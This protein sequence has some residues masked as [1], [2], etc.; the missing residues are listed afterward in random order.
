M[1]SGTLRKALTVTDPEG[2]RASA[3]SSRLLQES[4]VVAMD[5]LP[6]ASPKCFVNEQLVVGNTMY[7]GSRCLSSRA[8]TWHQLSCHSLPSAPARRALPRAAAQ[9]MGT[10]Q[11]DLNSRELNH[12]TALFSVLQLSV[13]GMWAQWPTPGI[14]GIL[15]APGGSNH[16]FAQGSNS[17]QHEGKGKWAF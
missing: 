2:S 14:K 10:L 3:A 8:P 13:Q 9:S 15:Q 5:R 4:S 7:K 16:L 1:A 17:H 11:K 6:A 12:L